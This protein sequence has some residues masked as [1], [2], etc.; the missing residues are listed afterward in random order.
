[1]ED[2]PIFIARVIGFEKGE[3]PLLS[4]RE[5]IIDDN[6]WNIVGPEGKS[7]HFQKFDDSN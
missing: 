1:M 5:S 2:S 7:I 6:K 3:K 4:S